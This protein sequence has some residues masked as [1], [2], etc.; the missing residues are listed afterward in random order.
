MT[1][2]YVNHLMRVEVHAGADLIGK[3]DIGISPTSYLRIKFPKDT[4]FPQQLESDYVSHNPNPEYNFTGYFL[5]NKELRGFAVEVWDHSKV[6]DDTLIGEVNIERPAVE[7]WYKPNGGWIPLNNKHGKLLLYVTVITV[8]DHPIWDHDTRQLELLGPGKAEQERKFVPNWMPLNSELVAVQIFSS[9]GYTSKIKDKIHPYVKVSFPL[10]PR[11]MFPNG[12]ITEAVLS[13][14]APE[15]NRS[16]FFLALNTH[17]QEMSVKVCSDGGK[18][19]LFSSTSEEIVHSSTRVALK[20]DCNVYRGKYKLA[21]T[22]NNSGWIELCFRRIPCA[23]FFPP[24]VSELP[25]RH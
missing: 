25:T 24:D 8:T 13:T 19:G 14:A 5:I 23:A 6:A 20:D 15:W 10:H 21:P 7:D 12:Q 2:L 1:Q 11:T 18:P 9:E 16:L 22:T 3:E 17:P 4:G